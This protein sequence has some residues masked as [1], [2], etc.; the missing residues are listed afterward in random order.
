M[1]E[2]DTR[3]RYTNKGEH[4]CSMTRTCRKWVLLSFG[5]KDSLAIV[6]YMWSRPI[7]DMFTIM[8]PQLYGAQ[9]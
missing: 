1:T 4:R 5:A 7:E 8:Y 2:W 6:V 9:V 3:T